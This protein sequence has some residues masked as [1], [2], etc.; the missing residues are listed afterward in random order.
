[1]NEWVFLWMIHFCEWVFLWMS[2]ISSIKSDKKNDVID[3]FVQNG[4]LV[5]CEWMFFIWS[6]RQR[7]FANG[8]TSKLLCSD[9]FWILIVV[10]N[11]NMGITWQIFLTQCCPQPINWLNVVLKERRVEPPLFLYF[12]HFIFILFF[13]IYTQTINRNYISYI[14][15]V[16][17]RLR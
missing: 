2:F 11:T 6:V 10:H 1:M 16:K 12:L 5:F 9:S 13:V 17:S 3:G 14:T 8:Q 4:V 7:K 15:D